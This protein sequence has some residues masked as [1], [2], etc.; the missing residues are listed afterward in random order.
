MVIAALPLPP[1]AVLLGLMQWW[2]MAQVAAVAVAEALPMGAREM[3][4][5]EKVMGREG[6][7]RVGSS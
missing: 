2:G 1:A 7:S 5:E 4:V 6:G 3:V